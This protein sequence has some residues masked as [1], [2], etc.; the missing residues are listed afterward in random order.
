MAQSKH[1]H[2][3]E[4]EGGIARKK[5]DKARPKLI[6]PHRSMSGIWSS[7]G[8]IWALKVL[9]VP[10][11]PAQLP[12]THGLSLSP[13]LLHAYR[14]LHWISQSPSVSTLPASCNTFS[15]LFVGNPALLH[16]AW[17]Q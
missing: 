6:K 7:C 12:V 14:V 2:F 5:Y 15:D 11:P 3:K 10:A 17:V 9:G 4:E 1:F 13:S 8:I 16:I